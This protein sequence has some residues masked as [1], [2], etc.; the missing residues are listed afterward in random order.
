MSKPIRAKTFELENGNKVD[1]KIVAGPFNRGL[2]VL[3]T[4]EGKR[5]TRHR[6][7]IEFVYETPSQSNMR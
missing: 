3:L 4:P 6:D 1:C 2:Y 5:V 7:N